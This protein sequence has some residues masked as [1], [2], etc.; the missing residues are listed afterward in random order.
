MYNILQFNFPKEF[1][2]IFECITTK[3]EPLILSYT[4]AELQ[5]YDGQ[6]GKATSSRYLQV[7]R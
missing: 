4:I 3:I 6:G 1:L 2:H 7:R 5:K